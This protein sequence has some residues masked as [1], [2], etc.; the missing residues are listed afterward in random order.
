M[1]PPSCAGLS[2]QA[3]LSL[4]PVRVRWDYDSLTIGA[5][6]F[7]SFLVWPVFSNWTSIM[8]PTTEI[9]VPAPKVWW[10]TVSPAAKSCDALARST[11]RST[12]GDTLDDGVL[13]RGAPEPKVEATRP[14]SGETPRWRSVP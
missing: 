4:A 9:T 5:K 12:V 14:A 7:I 1:W 11:L 2:E 13:A 6:P 10:L 8:S 3:T